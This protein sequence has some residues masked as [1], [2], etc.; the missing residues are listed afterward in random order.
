MSSFNNIPLL[1]LSRNKEIDDNSEGK[2]DL[3]KYFRHPNIIHLYE[4]IETPNEIIII[5]GYVQGGE[6]FD[7]ICFE[8]IIFLATKRSIFI[9]FD[10]IIFTITTISSISTRTIIPT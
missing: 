2:L 4:V 8:N 9:T 7:L 10:F 5:M 6:L 1:D 3:V